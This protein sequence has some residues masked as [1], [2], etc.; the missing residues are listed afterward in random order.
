MRDK[1]RGSCIS[2]R[3]ARVSFSA[4]VL[5]AALPSWA[6]AQPV[7]FVPFATGFDRVTDVANAGDERLFVVEQVG[8]I[9]IVDPDGTVRPTP[10]LDIRNR[11]ASGGELGLLG[12]AFHPDF[13]T[14]R[15]FY[16]NYTDLAGDT[17][18]ARYRVGPRDPNVVNPSTERV[19]LRQDQPF[20]N[21]N[22][23]DLAFGPADGYLYVA[24]GDGGNGCD[25]SGFAQNLRSLLGKILRI[26]VDG[27]FPYAIPPDNPFVGRSDVLPEIWSWGL[28]NPWRVSFD[29]RPP[30]AF[31]IADVGQGAREE[32][33]V[34]AGNSAGGE[35]YGWDCF[36]GRQAGT[37][38]AEVTCPPIGGHVLPAHDYAHDFGCSITGGF[39]YRGSRFPRFAGEY[40]FSDFC[41]EILWS[42]ARSGAGWQLTT[43]GATVP[44]GARTFGEDA[45]GELYVA[46]TTTVYRIED[47]RQVT[48]IECPATPSPCDLPGRAVLL[49]SD[50]APTGPSAADRLVFRLLRGPV[51]SPS[52]FGNPTDDTDLRL[53]VYDES[54]QLILQAVAS[55]GE[56]CGGAPCWSALGSTGFLYTDAAGAQDGLTRV[57]L[58][59]LPADPGTKIVFAGAGAELPLPSLPRPGGEDLFVRVHNSSNDACWGADFTP[60]DV[61]RNDATAF[62]AI[63]D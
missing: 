54:E 4:V 41:S 39:V 26:D 6:V 15:F 46:G 43:Y 16:V 33:N 30:H 3:W 32:V 29:R 22:G 25:P 31:Y 10:F 28:R 45:D 60:A 12:L 7:R 27:A 61:V 35:N 21:H 8:R 53:C 9:H 51:E 47:P 37:C 23:G 2:R 5:A 56:T 34:Q 17:V 52:A 13:A 62:K 20:A 36:E 1:S 49:I 19:I 18:V 57:L 63:A 38:T 50:A 14:N 44:E 58:R 48:P 24:L 59:P 55:G 42:L 11:V 40:F